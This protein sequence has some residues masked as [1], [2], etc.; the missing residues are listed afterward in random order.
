ML[1]VSILIP[2]WGLLLFITIVSFIV[3]GILV[4]RD[5]YKGAFMPDF[6][7]G[8]FYFG[9]WFILNLVMWLIYFIIV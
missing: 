3:T 7:T 4:K 6:T 1:L 8:I 2:I 9:I 5:T